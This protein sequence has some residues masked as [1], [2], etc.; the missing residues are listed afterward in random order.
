MTSVPAAPP[1]H[2]GPDVVRAGEVM[3]TLNDWRAILLVAMVLVALL[4]GALLTT[5]FFAFRAWLKSSEALG[6]IRESL[7]ATNVLLARFE[8][9]MAPKVDDDE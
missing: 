8:A 5:V 7:S 9:W 6:M 1:I 2:A 3:A 4:L